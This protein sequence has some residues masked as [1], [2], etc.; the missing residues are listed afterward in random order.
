VGVR[1]PE[2]QFRRQDCTPAGTRSVGVGWYYL[3]KVVTSPACGTLWQGWRPLGRITSGH[4]ETDG[5]VSMV[6]CGQLSQLPIVF[7]REKTLRCNSKKTKKTSLRTT[8]RDGDTWTPTE[9]LKAEEELEARGLCVTGQ[10]A[11]LQA[12]LWEALEAVGIEVDEHEFNQ[13][14]PKT[15]P[16]LEGRL[17]VPRSDA[18]VDMSS[19]LSVLQGIQEQ[20]RT[21]MT[22]NCSRLEVRLQESLAKSSSQVREQLSRIE[23]SLAELRTRQDVV[24]MELSTLNHKVEGEL[25]TLNH[26]FEAEIFRLDNRMRGLQLNGVV[27]GAVTTKLKAPTFDGT[28]PFKI[29]KLQFKMTAST[30]HWNN[31]DKVAALVV[32]LKGPAAEILQTVPEYARGDYDALMAAIERRFASEHRQ[33]IFQMELLNRYQTANETLQVYSTEI[34]RLARLAN[35]DAPAEFIESVKI[36][37]FVNGIR[38][39]GTITGNLFVADAN[40]R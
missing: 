9:N 11:D 1:G 39:V 6:E 32:S 31:E 27:T 25:Q 23:E 12:R 30:N 36:Q 37:S 3:E 33:Q 8:I 28:A 14:A 40:F 38:D 18:V 7:Q 13:G 10:E 17:E 35:A 22:E 2:D 4:I 29:F 16:R 34:E 20:I 5:Y 15:V 24:E 21:S 26:R 19:I